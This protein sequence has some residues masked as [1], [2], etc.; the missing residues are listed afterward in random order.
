ML[1]RPRRIV[2]T[3]DNTAAAKGADLLIGE[4]VNMKQVIADRRYDTNRSRAALPEQATI[5]VISGRHNC[6]PLI[7]YDEPRYK[8]R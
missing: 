5:P 3:P 7:Q 2:L 1:G 6:K 4:T 8:D